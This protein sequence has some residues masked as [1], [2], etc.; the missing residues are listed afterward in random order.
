MA[1]EIHPYHRMAYFLSEVLSRPT[2][3]GRILARPR[4]TRL[5]FRKNGSSRAAPDS[6]AVAAH[7]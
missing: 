5:D 2:L 7:D 3:A 4:V 6:L 1:N